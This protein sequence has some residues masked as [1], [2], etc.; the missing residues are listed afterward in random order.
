MEL[1]VLQIRFKHNLETSTPFLYLSQLG[2]KSA[3]CTAHSS[4]VSAKP[5][6]PPWITTDIILIMNIILISIC[7]FPQSLLTY[8]GW[9]SHFKKLPWLLLRVVSFP[10]FYTLSFAVSYY[11]N[12]NL[13][14]IQNTD[15]QAHQRIE[16]K[17]KIG[18]E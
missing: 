10:S 3:K 11:F 16:N 2:S 4:T 1:I 5:H 7:Q 8:V 18:L 15:Q 6:K 9:F 13:L 14:W 17:E 12:F